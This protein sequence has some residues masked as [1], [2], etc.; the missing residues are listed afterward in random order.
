MED[1]KQKSHKKSTN[2]WY[3]MVAV[4]IIGAILG[5]VYMTTNG[6]AANIVTVG[7]NVSVY[8]TGKFTNN[9]IFDSNVGGEPLNFTVGSGEMISGFDNAVIGMKV[10]ETK[11]ITLTPQ[12]AYGEVNQSLIYELPLS[13][14][15]NHSVSVGMSIKTTSGAQGLITSVNS[16]TATVDFNPPL[17]GKTLIFEIKVAAIR[18]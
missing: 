2:L 7:D 6:N 17:A 11:N 12:E 10:G 4:I 18:K 13:D 8:Y 9:T 5:V 16:T 14:F 15:G 3:A 1:N